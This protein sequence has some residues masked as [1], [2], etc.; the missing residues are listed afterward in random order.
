M[1]IMLILIEWWL[2]VTSGLRALHNMIS[3]NFYF[4]CFLGEEASSES[5]RTCSRSHSNWVAG[6]RVWVQSQT[7]ESR[8]LIISSSMYCSRDNTIHLGFPGEYMGG[9]GRYQMEKQRAGKPNSICRSWATVKKIE[10]SGWFH[11]CVA[12][13]WTATV[14]VCTFRGRPRGE[15]CPQG[16]AYLICLYSSELIA[17]WSSEGG[18]DFSETLGSHLWPSWVT[19]VGDQLVTCFILIEIKCILQQW[20]WFSV[21]FWR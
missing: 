6:A 21:L 20:D 18:L 12:H 1:M 10:P 4:H 17:Y 13:F 9:T 7:L 11:L 8:V 16:W 3:A 19:I 15:C 2:Y 5:L 14:G